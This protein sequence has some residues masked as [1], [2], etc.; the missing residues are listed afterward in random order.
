VQPFP[1]TIFITEKK[2]AEPAPAP[3]PPTKQQ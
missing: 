2:G 1:Q 3:P